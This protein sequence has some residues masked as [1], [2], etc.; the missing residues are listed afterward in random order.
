MFATK[1]ETLVGA[2]RE[3]SIGW[4]HW[5]RKAGYDAPPEE[6]DEMD[7]DGGLGNE[8]LL[9]NNEILNNLNY[10]SE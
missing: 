3:G 4:T 1:L 5:L 8:D 2:P 9:E 7:F 6:R 10:E